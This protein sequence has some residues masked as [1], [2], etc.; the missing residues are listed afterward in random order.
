MA[1]LREIEARW[2][3]VVTR[4][5][6]SVALT[7]ADEKIMR[8]TQQIFQFQTTVASEDASA[9]RVP[10]HM[11][12]YMEQAIEI[13][14]GQIGV[15]VCVN[16]RQPKAVGGVT[17]EGVASL[18]IGNSW[19]RVDDRVWVNPARIAYLNVTD[20]SG[21]DS[22]Q[23]V[24]QDTRQLTISDAAVGKANSISVGLGWRPRRLP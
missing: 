4:N 14:S 18:M 1:V 20:V 6:S 17:V 12:N 7:I 16:S 11:L 19:Y 2:N 9:W 15:S 5:I 10:L 3:D 24:F 22:V 21:A 13:V 23:I 8:K